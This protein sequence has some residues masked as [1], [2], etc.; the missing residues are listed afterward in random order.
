MIKIS[1]TEAREKLPKLTN[2]VYFNAKTFLITKRGI[3]MAKISK[4]ENA[5]KKRK[6]SEKQVK[7]AIKMARGLR[8][9]WNEE[10]KN[11]STEEVVRLLREK[12]W[13]SHAS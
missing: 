13:N 2:E 1:I 9:V 11:K 6:P 5:T 8:G 10:W 12:A 4:P 3:P 7:R